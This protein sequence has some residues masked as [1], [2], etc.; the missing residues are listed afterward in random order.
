M[1]L[2]SVAASLAVTAGAAKAD[3]VPYWMV[4]QGDMTVDGV[5]TAA[6]ETYFMDQPLNDDRTIV[7]G[8]LWSLNTKN[9]FLAVKST[10]SL[11]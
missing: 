11:G 5:F 6:N 9:L 4:N 3:A 2:A 8:G 10:S 1:L 7:A